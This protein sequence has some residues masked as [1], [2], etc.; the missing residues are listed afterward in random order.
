[1]FRFCAHV[2][3]FA[4]LDWYFTA[5]LVT[6]TATGQIFRAAAF[7]SLRVKI[8]L[9]IFEIRPCLLWQDSPFSGVKHDVCPL[10]LR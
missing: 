9:L 6:V 2:G 8:G 7:A 5:R 1:M 10:M 4:P 3:R